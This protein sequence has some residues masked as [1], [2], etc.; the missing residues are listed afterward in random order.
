MGYF[1]NYLEKKVLDHILKTASYSPPAS[2][3][4]FSSLS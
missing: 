3:S 1:T 2:S 4:I